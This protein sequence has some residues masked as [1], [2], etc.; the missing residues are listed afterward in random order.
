MALNITKS[1]QPL[2]VESII[3]YLY[4]DPGIGKST[5]AHTAEKPVVFDFDKGSHRVGNK[6]RRGDVVQVRQWSDVSGMVA[7]DLVDYQT[8][9]CDTVG[10]MLDC[11]KTHLSNNAENRQRDGSLTIKAQGLAN[12]MFMQTIHKWISYGKDVVFIAHAVEEESG[13]DKIKVFRPDLGGKNRNMLYRMADVMGYMNSN[14][15]EEGVMERIINFCPSPTHHAKNSGNLGQVLVPDL[16]HE[17][18]FLAQL[19]QQS[20]DYINSMT[21]EQIAETK[22]TADLQNFE[23]NCEEANY[24]SDLNQ[25][26]ESLDPEHRYTK[27]MWY[28]IQI[29]ARALKCTF[30]K[31]T[32]RW[33]NPP[34]FKGIS[35]EQRDEI[36]ELLNKA[37]ID[38]M[39]FCEEQGIESLI[40]IQAECLE[41]VK[42]YIINKIPKQGAVA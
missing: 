23:Q 5:L 14:T 40:G 25:L 7:G 2:L 20:K 30:N 29:R 27:Q 13:K 4:T 22:A 17:A 18:T 28:A 12:N 21:P 26:T 41:A 11:I 1:S 33:S 16:E 15:N 32:K 3:F 10:A 39:S 6:L 8:I 24:A 9:V 38:V 34:D 36:Q 37:E 42:A 31:E 35:D 19:I